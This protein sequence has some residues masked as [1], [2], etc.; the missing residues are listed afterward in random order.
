MNCN[1]L[2][3]QSKTG[4]LYW[5]IIITFYGRSRFLEVK[6]AM[7][8]HVRE[9]MYVCTSVCLHLCVCVPFVL[10]NAL[11]GDDILW[12][13]Q[14]NFTSEQNTNKCCITSLSIDL[15]DP[16]QR[17]LG[18]LKLLNSLGFIFNFY[19]SFTRLC[20]FMQQCR[21]FFVCRGRKRMWNSLR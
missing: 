14:R 9:C 21:C 13:S 4:F 16:S 6:Y 18:F 2:S 3:I 15:D 20:V 1:I 17:A 8:R 7:Y 12:K 19:F 10:H 5:Q 11:R